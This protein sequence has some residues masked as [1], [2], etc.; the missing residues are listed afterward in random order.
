MQGVS[1][2]VSALVVFIA[3][4][5][6][7]QD[8]V[9]LDCQS[10]WTRIGV[11]CYKLYKGIVPWESAVKICK[12][13]GAEMAKVTDF[14]ENQDVGNFA[15][16]L[17][18]DKYWIGYSRYIYSKYGFTRRDASP[19]NQRIGY[20]SDGQVT[21]IAAGF[22][23]NDQ[24]DSDKFGKCVYVMKKMDT[25]YWSF[26]PCEMK[27]S[28]VCQRPA[29][30]SGSYHCTNGQ[31]I[32]Q[33][34]VCDG[35]DDCGDASDERNCASRCKYYLNQAAGSISSNN[36]PSNYPDARNCQWVIH[37]PLGQNVY[38]K[39]TNFSTE[40]GADIVQ[41]LVGGQ[42][43]TQGQLVA[44]L[45]G[46]RQASLPEFTSFNN[47]I[48][49]KF[50][51]DS[52]S[53][54]LGF[55]AEFSGRSAN[56]QPFQNLQA[57]DAPK[58]LNAPNY[59]SMYFGNKDYTWIINTLMQTQIITLNIMEVD[60]KGMD[61]IMIRNGDSVKANLLYMFTA[62]TDVGDVPFIFSTGNSMYI[63]MQTRGYQVG[64][65]FRFTYRQGCDMLLTSMKGR[66]FSP[67]YAL[68][69]NTAMNYSNDI[70]CNFRVDV[71]GKPNITLI[72]RGFKTQT[73]E[74][75]VT[76]HYGGASPDVLSGDT[77]VQSRSNNG[78]FNVTF[79]TNAIIREMGFLF[80]YSIDC[81]NPNFN[82]NTVLTPSNANWQ[83][84]SEFVVTC[85]DGYRFASQEDQD[86][87]KAPAFESFSV[88]RMKCMYGGKWDRDTTPSCQPKYCGSAPL[89]NN[90]YV[91]SSTGQSSSV[92]GSVTY[93]CYPGFTLSNSATISCRNDGTWGPTP[94]CTIASCSPLSTTLNFGTVTKVE[95]DGTE[96]G[97]IVNFTCNAGYQISG[98]PILFCT[99]SSTWTANV[100]SCIPLNCPIPRIPH[101]RLTSTQEAFFGV[102]RQVTCDSGYRLNT[103]SS[104]VTCGAD[105]MFTNLDTMACEDI[106]E[107]PGPCAQDCMNTDGSYKCSCRPGYTL[108]ANGRSCDDVNECNADNG[109][110]SQVCVNDV[111][112]YKCQ[113]NSGYQLFSM[114]GQLNYTLANNEDGTMAGDIYRF[115]HTCVRIQ[116]MDP[117][118]LDNGYILNS[119]KYYRF[120]D[121]IIMSCNIGFN[122]IGQSLRICQ[123]NGRWNGTAPTC[124]PAICP[125]VSI[126]G[127]LKTTPSVTPSGSV[128]YLGNVNISCNVP[129]RVSFLKQRQC[130][131]D[132]DT[133]QYK[134]FGAQ[135][136]CGVIDCGTPSGVPGAVIPAG[137]QTTYGTQFQFVCKNQYTKEGTSSLNNDT[138]QCKS[139]GYWGWG[140]L[141][142][143]GNTCSDPGRPVD[144]TQHA[145][146]YEEN[147]Q[148][149]YTCNRPGYTLQGATP[150]TCI[151]DIGLKWNR[152]VPTCVDTQKPTFSNCVA[153]KTV[154]KY[155][156]AS[157]AVTPPTPSDNTGIKS[158]T[159]TPTWP[160]DQLLIASEE[161]FVFTAEDF[162]GNKEF[163]TTKVKVLD[164]V[165]PTIR[166]P[167]PVVE[168]FKEETD[169]KYWQFSVSALGMIV[170]DDSGSTPSVLFNPPALN[171]SAA[172]ISQANFVQW[173]TATAIDAAGNRNTCRFQVM[174]KAAICSPMSIP[175]PVNG[176]KSCTALINNGGY[177]CDLTCDANYAFYDQSSQT[178]V[179]TSC[180]T[181]G[182]F[183]KAVIPAC[184]FTQSETA[185][186]TQIIR[187]SYDASTASTLA[188]TCKQGY[189][190]M[191]T[192][193]LN[194]QRTRLNN[195]C[196]NLREVPTLVLLIASPQNDISINTATNK[197]IINLTLIYEG[198]DTALLASCATL[199]DTILKDFNFDET[200]AIAGYSSQLLPVS[201]PAINSTSPGIET[202]RDFSCASN[203]KKLTL[204]SLIACLRCPVGTYNSG[205]NTCTA[206]PLGQYNDVEGAT[207]CKDC[208]TGQWTFSI[209]A[210]SNL[211]CRPMC[212][213]GT[214]SSTRLPPCK[215][216]PLNTIWVNSTYCRSCGA[217]EITRVYAATE[218]SQCKAQCGA[219]TYNAIDGHAECIPCPINFY[220]DQV[221]QKTCK[222]C[223][224]NE[225]TAGPGSTAQSNCTSGALS[226]VCTNYCQNGGSCSVIRH[227]PSCSCPE[228]YSGQR[229][230]IGDNPCASS[231]C[232]NGGACN[233][234]NVTTYSCSCPAGTSGPRCETDVNDCTSSTLCQNG[235]M[236]QDQINTFKCLCKDGFTGTICT[237][238]QPI[239]DSLPC[240]NG[241][242]NPIGSYRRECTCV[243]GFTGK[244]C[245]TNIDDCKDN[246][247]LYGGTCID[248]VNNYTC[249]CPLGFVG[250]RCETRRNKCAGV[251]C[252]N[253]GQCIEDHVEN[254]YRCICNP[255][256]SYGEYCEYSLSL[257]KKLETPTFSRNET[258]K[259]LMDCRDTCNSQ[260]S[261]C[262]AFS[263]FRADQR[264]M[265]HSTRAGNL[266]PLVPEQGASYYVKK[267]SYIKDDFYTEWYNTPDNRTSGNYVLLSDM[268]NTLQLDICG[269]SFPIDIQCRDATTKKISTNV[270]SQC[271]LDQGF[272]CVN[273]LQTAGTTCNQ[274]EIRFKCGVS[275]VFKEKTCSIPPYCASSP[276]MNG[277]SCREVG[278][279]FVCDC[280]PGY[281]GSLCQKNLDNCANQP[282]LNGG[283]CTDGVNTFT[284]KCAM[285]YEGS[286]CAGTINFCNPNPCNSTGS[287]QCTSILTGPFCHCKPGYDNPVCSNNIDECASSPCLHNGVCTDGINDFTCGCKDGWTGKRCESLVTPCS[288]SPCINNAN[289]FDIF[290]NYFCRCKA[291]TYGQKCQFA[292]SICSNANPCVN[293][294]CSESAGV[295]TCAC[296]QDYTGKGCEVQVHHCKADTCKNKAE[297]S[298]PSL[299]NYNCSCPKGFTGTNCDT[300]INNCAGVSC[301]GT[302]RCIDG[303]DQYF[304]RCP[305]G[306]SGIDCSQ[307][308]DRNYDMLFKLP[309][310]TSHAY[311]PYPIQ[312]TANK[313]SV[314]LWVK[315]WEK[316]GTGT[317]FTLYSVDGPNSLAGK[318]ELIRIDH[319]GLTISVNGTTSSV[320]LPYFKYNDGKWNQI[321]VTWNGETGLLNFVVNTI[322]EDVQNY[323]KGMMI[324]KYVWMVLG[325]KYDPVTEMPVLNEGFNG[326]LSQVSLY[327]RDLTFTS[328]IPLKLEN[329]QQVFTDEIF[330]WNEFRR[331]QGVSLVIP[332][333]ASSTSCPR[334]YSGGNC[335]VA[336]EKKL[337]V[338]PTKC[339]GDIVQ[340]GTTRITEVT[341]D[342][343]VFEGKDSTIISTH[344]SRDVFLW[345]R[346]QVVY[347]ASNSAGNK[348]LCSFKIFIQ[349]S[350]CTPLQNPIRGNAQ[351][352]V[353]SDP[354]ITTSINCDSGYS[355]VHPVPKLYTCPRIG[356]YNPPMKYNSFRLPPCGVIVNNNL[357]Q[358]IVQLF[359]T[360]ISTNPSGIE[361]SMRTEIL[362]A[363]RTL[364]A[365]WSNGLCDKTDCSDAVINIQSGVTTG[366]RKRQST[367]DT[368]VNITLPMAKASSSLGSLRLTPDDILRLA[369][370]NQGKF[371]FSRNI[372]NAVPIRDLVKIL[373]SISCATGQAVVNG[374]CVKCAPGTYYNAAT[375]TCDLCPVGQY[376]PNEAQSSCLPCGSKTTEL[377]GSSSASDCKVTC[378]TGHRFDNAGNTCLPCP[379]GFYQNMTGQF[380]CYPCSVE[381]TTRTT[382][383]ISEGQCYVGCGKGH[384]LAPNGTCQECPLGKYRSAVMSKCEDCATGLTTNST[385]ADAMSLCNVGDC[386]AGFFRNNVK[387]TECLK[388]PRGTYQDLKQQYSCKACGSSPQY[389]TVGDGSTSAAEC[390]FVC[391]DGFQRFVQ[392]NVDTCIPCPVGFYRNKTLLPYDVCASCG[393]D[394]STASTHSKSFSDCSILKCPVGQQPD[395]TNANCVNCPFGTYQNQSNQPNCISCTGQTSTRQ[396]GSQSRTQCEAY[397]NGGQEKLADGSCRTCP[398]GYYKDNSVYKFMSCEK[399]PINFVTSA[400]GAD[401]AAKC[402]IYQCQAGYKIVGNGC[403]ACPVGYYQPEPYKSSCKM[404]PGN[405]STRQNATVNVTQCEAHCPSGSDKDMTTGQCKPCA[406][407]FYK[408]NSAGVF[409]ECVMCSSTFITA[410][411]GSTSSSDCSVHNCTAGQKTTSTGC[412]DCPKGSYQSQKWQTN[413][414]MCATDKTTST[415]GATSATDCILSCPPGKEDIAGVCVL[416]KQG[417]YKS[418]QKASPCMECPTNKTTSGSGAIASTDCNQ[419]GC[420]AGYFQDSSTSCQPCTYG[421][422]QP[423]KWQSNCDKCDTG[424]TT[425]SLGAMAV[426]D[427]VVDCSK[428]QQFN[429]GTGKCEQCPQGYYQDK[430][431]P[432]LSQ[433][434]MCF[435]TNVITA[436]PGATSAASC[437]V[438]N[439]TTPGQ[440]RNSTTNLCEDCPVRTYQDTKWQD[441]CKTCATGYTTRNTKSP[442][443][444]SCLRDCEAGKTQIGDACTD[445]PADFYRNKTTWT[446]QPCP[447]GLKTSN[448]GAPSVNACNVSACLQ[449]TYF[450]RD[451]SRCVDCPL[452]YYQDLVS[453]FECKKCPSSKFTTTM[454]S[455]SQSDC[456]GFCDTSNNCSSNARCVEDRITKYKC[457]CNANFQGNGFTCT[458]V[459]DLDYCKHGSTCTRG[460]PAQC[461]CTE[462][463][464]GDQCDIRRAA[465]LVSNQ[466]TLT[467]VGLVI[468]I[469]GFILLL[470][471]IAACLYRRRKPAPSR[472]TPSE[473]DDRASLAATRGPYDYPLAYV[474]SKTASVISG[475]RYML[476]QTVEKSFD[477]PQYVISDDDPAVYKA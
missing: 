282:C 90:A 122:L 295:T 216:C 385:G 213:S 124:S 144:G 131:L 389:I 21:S 237:S 291:N 332:S 186:F 130:L 420:P 78:E 185:K 147:N 472:Q 156:T 109:G 203:R 266:L 362:S 179:T 254:T 444:A 31:C 247:C 178:T 280:A 5:T 210:S 123:A 236:C 447:A 264:C 302:S 160:S 437:T 4:K 476:P 440:Y 398:L 380:F 208:S 371:D 211:M 284:C 262:R 448:V 396:N 432:E 261:S 464:M 471:L 233:I 453:T 200:K 136:E 159:I 138:V 366:R 6:S 317:F 25:Y 167:D 166:C 183:D 460:P 335:E 391:E 189:A 462:F 23:E 239:C 198:R 30:P 132:P 365:E 296:G 328:E 324:D 276:C 349:Y 112:S 443:S 16:S 353:I 163:C 304:C 137:I 367:L 361:T 8:D 99:S 220:Q 252:G 88:A 393:P 446:C 351:R 95:G 299:N 199:V 337:L 219:G 86:K 49:V 70:S 36:Y 397:C 62:D 50:T 151:L 413:C 60:L 51:S 425:Y 470:I 402:N 387:Q 415:S 278:L 360:V 35:D 226:P 134:L 173:V 229:C 146:S 409:S 379:I 84:M 110:C 73:S 135:L 157:N 39:F 119:R 142:C 97:S 408:A 354:L 419:I 277:A 52:S 26:G 79:K 297:C 350:S 257:N 309:Q 190:T 66:L 383:S 120:E 153:E 67:G 294:M 418:E 378:T 395:S 71:P 96:F 469:L 403:E 12:S 107:C 32:N 85:K 474:P 42:T 442:S 364:N 250:P 235:G 450:K 274:H 155:T 181:D 92:G 433:C 175:K 243:A 234:L 81:P 41:V 230:E 47:F 40:M 459:C 306:K 382:A 232:Y 267:C 458:H 287:S 187:F 275:R 318:K 93:S 209:G 162:N 72:N 241:V 246:P 375:M 65:G 76:V 436:G 125:P 439:C 451:E 281:G 129:G 201:C 428:G 273:S 104:Q 325:S 238:P 48:I 373:L 24:P 14:Y 152:P 231:P 404:C 352:S 466:Q 414:A 311:L 298:A 172:F 411:T 44:S 140:T 117:P 416:C 221:G 279:T 105:Q 449:G 249:Q 320:K 314:S 390:R 407:G 421:F 38:L 56:L 313:L 301:P 370:L 169:H 149:N 455:R 463:Y 399:C 341:W 265:L 170:S 374:Q 242:C 101:G 271:I 204:G 263:Y 329:P 424:S 386:Q 268:R 223:S 358:V 128:D 430:L 218:A 307:D 454:G 260:G 441:S 331:S 206:C 286:T 196:L 326:W 13:Y 376:Q 465:E 113:C 197:V 55:R 228:G 58:F 111:G 245:E 244:N 248:E 422:Y 188:D 161:D 322:A 61:K 406:R 431:N 368:S 118:P 74:D 114:D 477:N 467:I 412:V 46:D 80:E 63:T 372:P 64:K 330:A 100:P 10:G 3:V 27:L 106:D 202:F 356:S 251:T 348:G 34:L 7:F 68:D 392:Q 269:G 270:G 310:K 381:K 165:P 194:N 9:P 18:T 359:Y 164:E 22:W 205:G 339:P 212:G 180:I 340:L 457:E 434:I 28:Y 133:K 102:L 217:N 315:F 75:V 121:R 108:N 316:D 192:P 29:C 89:V 195:Y 363:L 435:D 174:A 461:Q 20:W 103:S 83:F 225:V 222:A 33:N 308:L 141:R 255:E 224:T 357:Y 116:C 452:N 150:L 283:T 321:A 19:G 43:E 346:Y 158:M 369:V 176:Q 400:P 191:M 127:N 405:T 423:K 54:A 377:A 256:A 193:V 355:I 98:E 300:N 438:K 473:Y 303:V 258:G 126:P 17:S 227:S 327:N 82:E 426:T 87:S 312:L 338:S 293:G 288:S 305:V 182:P 1:L 445:C 456:V 343:P 15:S 347:L 215:V 272:K 323:A 319:S 69:G 11:Q 290:S 214:F 145:T 333:T 139:N 171:I 427:C 429:A 342:D 77:V 91:N 468:G 184:S 168:E 253:R 475:P 143:L 94:T 240:G 344:K 177:R 410:S 388:C 384:Q 292:P 336:D 154:S 37:V 115:N 394:R 45:S 207:T 345:G 401:S 53:N 289:C 57:I 148:V 259:T 334:G 285:G 417:F 59:P 2:W